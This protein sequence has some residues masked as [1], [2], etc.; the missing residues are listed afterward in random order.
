MEIMHANISK[1]G[2]KG[3]INSI[4]NQKYLH[5]QSMNLRCFC[6]TKIQ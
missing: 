6:N 2:K 1:N 3:E 5:N 4:G